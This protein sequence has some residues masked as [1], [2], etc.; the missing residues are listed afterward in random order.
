MARITRRQLKRNDLAET[1]GRTVDYVSHHRRGAT[2]AIGAAAVVL[3]LAAGFFLFRG[4]RERAA[5]RE[6]SE[7][8]AILDAPLASDPAAATA[9]RTY[10][11]AAEREREASRHLDAAAK[12]G[13]TEAGRAARVIVAARSDKPA[14]AVNVLTKVAREARME[15]AAVAEIDAARLLAA[16]GKTNEAIERLKRGFKSPQA[17]A[18]KDAL[19][20]VLAETYEKAGNAAEARATY[21]RIVNDYP[22]SPY[23]TPAREKL[24]S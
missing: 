19:L 17:A 1:F 3:L 16:T 21:Q 7:A 24:G 4:W 9:S 2:E 10:P 5:G 13:G 15:V 22:N 6:L 11:T 14:E 8:L 12:K 23:R 18:P 20:F